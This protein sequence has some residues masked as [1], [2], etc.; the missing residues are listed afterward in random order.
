MK[1][2]RKALPGYDIRGI[3]WEGWRGFDALHCRTRAVFD[4]HM[5]KISNAVINEGQPEN[6]PV[7]VNTTI[8]D[9]SKKGLIKNEL[10]IFWRINGEHNWKRIL[11]KKVN[12][13]AFQAEIPGQEKGKIVEYYIV[14]SSK[15]G[16]KETL[17]RTVPDGFYSFSI[18]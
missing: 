14:A 4:R 11:L 16:R 6:K 5:I 12:E 1:T 2:Y 15:S 9:Y 10:A 13:N 17:P 3:K 7:S 18:E 8:I